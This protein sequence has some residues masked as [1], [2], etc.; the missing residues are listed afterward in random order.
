[1][2]FK[3][4][5]NGNT[6]T[7]TPTK[8]KRKEVNNVT[9]LDFE[10]KHEASANL[11]RMGNAI[12]KMEKKMVKIKLAVSLDSQG[13]LQTIALVIRICCLKRNKLMSV[14]FYQKDVLITN[15]HYQRSVF[16]TH[17]WEN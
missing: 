1:M 11:M 17:H 16:V 8:K 10:D 2:F 3:K 15:K 14:A 7:F 12:L 6:K 9:H 4:Q 5:N 13:E